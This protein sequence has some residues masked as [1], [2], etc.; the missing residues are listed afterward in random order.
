MEDSLLRFYEERSDTVIR[1]RPDSPP[2]VAHRSGRGSGNRHGYGC[3]RQPHLTG[4][5]P[6]RGAAEARTL[7]PTPSPPEAGR[8]PGKEG[9]ARRAMNGRSEREIFPRPLWRGR[10][11][12]GLRA[13][14]FVGRG[15]PECSPESPRGLQ[16]RASRRCL[17]AG[18]PAKPVAGAGFTGRRQGYE[19]VAR[20]ATLQIGARSTK[21]R[22][23]FVE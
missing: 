4:S 23:W 2:R 1:W 3:G 12:K 13:P 21:R 5:L 15:G 16:D 18:H 6:T 8:R 11:G 20:I 9:L 7:P 14:L 17:A 10:Q 22:G 19:R